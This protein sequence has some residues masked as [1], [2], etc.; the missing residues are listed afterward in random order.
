MSASRSSRKARGHQTQNAVAEWFAADGWP[1]ATSAGAGRP[2][3]DVLGM[4]NLSCEVKAR[5]DLNVLAWLRQAAA[6]EGLPFVVWR[7]DGM[8]PASIERWPV[9]TTL[10]HFTELLHAAGYPEREGEHG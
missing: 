10:E 7:P 8:G 1:H 4:P 2:G 9:M 3:V 5:R 6:S